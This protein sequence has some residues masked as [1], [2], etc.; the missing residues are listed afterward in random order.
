MTFPAQQNLFGNIPDRVDRSVLQR[1]CWSRHLVV[2]RHSEVDALRTPAYVTAK[3]SLM[4][5]RLGSAWRDGHR[6][7]PQPLQQR[8]LA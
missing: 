6:A 7:A 4:R 5:I 1:R 3:S 8:A 2:P